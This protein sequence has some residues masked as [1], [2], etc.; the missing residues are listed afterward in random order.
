MKKDEVPQDNNRT[1]GGARKAVYATDEQGR[2]GITAT[3]G[4][5][6][7]EIVTSLAA[8]DFSLNAADAL[9][10]GLAGETSPLEFHMYRMRMDIPTLAQSTGVW[11]W[12]IRRHFKP[13]VFAQL[14]AKQLQRYADALGMDI[15]ALKSLPHE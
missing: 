13:Q 7:E 2:Y 3:S 1:L 8:E 15:D 12:R 4:W 5:R 6:V 9:E 14:S 11:Q 10:R